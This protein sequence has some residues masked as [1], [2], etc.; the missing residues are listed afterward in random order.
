[1]VWI[2]P[3]VNLRL[4]RKAVKKL[5]DSGRASISKGLEDVLSQYYE[6]IKEDML[7]EFLR[8]RR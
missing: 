6:R 3:C 5:F 1:M 7:E 4:S 2:M 8:E